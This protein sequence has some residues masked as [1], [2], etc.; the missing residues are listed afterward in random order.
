MLLINN[1]KLILGTLLI[2]LLGIACNKDQKQAENSIEGEWNVIAINS[3]YGEFF[4]NGINISE[5]VM[6]TGGLGNFNFT[7]DKVD[8]EF[9]R[10]DTLYTG[11]GPWNI[12][13]ER[14]NAGFTKVTEFTLAME[15]HFLFDARFEDETKNAEKNARRVS[16]IETP[17]SGFGV[18]IEL[19]LEKK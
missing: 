16:L 18:L 1:S 19:M 6:E 7:S 12:T 4:E 15:D 17:T 8:F 2:C 10:N 14:V 11:N 3:Y 13:A 5:E 9:N